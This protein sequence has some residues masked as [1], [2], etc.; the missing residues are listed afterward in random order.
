MYY[1]PEL[2]K[3]RRTDGNIRR[4]AAYNDVVANQNVRYEGDMWVI[5]TSFQMREPSLS[6]IRT[7]TATNNPE[8]IAYEEKRLGMIEFAGKFNDFVDEYNWRRQLQEASDDQ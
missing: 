2:Q 7:A 3:I 4:W 1:G 5:Q 6:L 8:W